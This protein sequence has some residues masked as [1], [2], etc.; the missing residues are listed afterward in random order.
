[1]PGLSDIRP[2]RS[3]RIARSRGPDYCCRRTELLI[4]SKFAPCAAM[5]RPRTRLPLGYWRRSRR[6]FAACS[7]VLSTQRNCTIPC[8]GV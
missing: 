8:S 1:L 4:L 7:R 6:D 3:G 2:G 5:R